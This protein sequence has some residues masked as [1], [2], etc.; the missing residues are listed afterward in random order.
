ML[1]EERRVG[2]AGIPSTYARAVVS[3]RGTFDT[4][5]RA[6]DHNRTRCS[7]SNRRGI[8]WPS[9]ETA[10]SRG[11][12]A[13]EAVRAPA[14]HPN[15]GFIATQSGSGQQPGLPSG[16]ST[17]GHNAKTDGRWKLV[18]R[19][20]VVDDGGC[21]RGPDSPRAPGPTSPCRGTRESA[22]HNPGRRANGRQP[23]NR[24]RS[25]VAW[26][27]SRI[28]RTASREPPRLAHA[29]SSGGNEFV[30]VNAQSSPAPRQRPR[31]D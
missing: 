2:R 10:C 13:A 14:E 30:L 1:L 23:S 3:R 19:S 31:A 26:S 21:C 16:T 29:D 6:S 17:G 12:T 28:A 18:C 24:S 8:E 7:R 25:S 15:G 4:P 20:V 5:C 11:R 9:P 22:R 27:T